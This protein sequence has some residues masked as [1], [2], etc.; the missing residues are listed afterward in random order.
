MGDKHRYT[1]VC[2]EQLSKSKNR[3]R[4]RFANIFNLYR[5]LYHI[6]LWYNQKRYQKS[7]YKLHF[8]YYYRIYSWNICSDI[9][10]PK[11]L[12]KT[13]KLSRYHTHIYHSGFRTIIGSTFSKGESDRHTNVGDFRNCNWYYDI[14]SELR[15]IAIIVFGRR[16]VPPLI[17]T[18]A[19]PNIDRGRRRRW[20]R[21]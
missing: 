10:I 3:Y 8:S 7:K 6:Q 14:V 11:S 19:L 12:R 17:L 15:A 20:G 16:R 1:K 21:W 5:V 4:R 18:V 9:I 13:Q 2:T